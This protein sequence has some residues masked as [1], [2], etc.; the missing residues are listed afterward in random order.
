[1]EM[2]DDLVFFLHTKN[3]LFAW[4]FQVN[5]KEISSKIIKILNI[6]CRPLRGEGKETG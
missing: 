2:T 4:K 5:F 1:M 3:V 6:L